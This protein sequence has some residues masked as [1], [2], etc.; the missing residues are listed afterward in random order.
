VRTRYE[1]V[2]ADFQRFYGIDLG[3]LWTGELR[4]HRA[5][6]LTSQ[7]PPGAAIFRPEGLD[8]Q[9]YSVEAQLLRMLINMRIERK[10]ERIPTADEAMARAKNKERASQ[11]I[12]RRRQTAASHFLARIREQQEAVS[13]D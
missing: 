11:Q 13:D 5:A 9:I 7:L 3:G 8:S 1:A 10:S 12:K 2:E 6:R 4:P